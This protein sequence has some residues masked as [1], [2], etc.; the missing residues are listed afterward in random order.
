MNEPAEAE[1][2]ELS[3]YD[4]EFSVAYRHRVYFTRNAFD[5]GNP[6]LRDILVGPE[7]ADAG[8]LLVTL[9]QGVAGSYPSLE[10][11][12]TTYFSEAAATP[13]LVC[14]PV[15]LPGGEQAKSGW[16]QVSTVHE[17]IHRHRICRHSHV[18]AI[19]GGAHLD[20]VGFAAATAHRGVGHVRM[21]STV[22]AQA[23]SGVGVKNG[24]NA[25]GQKNFV[26]SFAPPL[27][28][29]NDFALLTALP[30]TQKRG[31]LAE[32]V[33]IALIRDR[34]FFETIAT[35]ADALAAFEP[36]A[37]EA[38]IVRCARLHVQHIVSCGDPFERGS[39]RP[40]DFGHWAAH[41]L[42]CLSGYRLGHGDAVAIGIA[43]DTLYSARAGLLAPAD[44]GRVVGL[45]ER[46][47]F[48]LWTPELELAETDGR[49]SVL[50]GL[51]DF[52]EHLGGRLTVTLLRDLGHGI[53]VH[54]MNPEWIR[55]A[56]GDLAGRSGS[57]KQAETP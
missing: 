18:L 6:W 1:Q 37:L 31:G 49:L 42:E 24:I 20:V 22:L 25:F 8:R 51:N 3:L 35:Q 4:H 45:L 57:K 21:P 11:R 34:D 32:A 19:G 23:D 56:L 5:P 29:L 55:E 27:A 47:G 41:K 14:P 36:T 10:E 38:L 2:Y 40:L 50:N 46:L 15:V 13:R 53:D 43:L 12:I 7:H 28:V 16:S 52:R 9:D 26:G 54:E 44:A 39:A 33:K 30:P 48:P 17:L